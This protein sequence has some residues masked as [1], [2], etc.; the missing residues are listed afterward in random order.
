MLLIEEKTRL[1]SKSSALSLYI[2]PFIK[3]YISFSVP[4]F[5]LC[6]NKAVCQIWPITC[7]CK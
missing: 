2:L 3:A 6:I 4:H 1:F 7:F 5:I